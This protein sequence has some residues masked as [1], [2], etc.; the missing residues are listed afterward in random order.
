MYHALKFQCLVER[1]SRNAGFLLVL[2][3]VY[4]CRLQKESLSLNNS[5]SKIFTSLFTSKIY[6]IKD[7]KKTRNMG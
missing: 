1:N 5:P 4:S 7:V 2:E 3:N 6:Q